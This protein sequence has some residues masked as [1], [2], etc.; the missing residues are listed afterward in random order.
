MRHGYDQGRKNYPFLIT[1]PS[2][3]SYLPRERH[4]Q[5]QSIAQYFLG[6]PIVIFKNVFVT[7]YSSRLNKP[8]A[9]ITQ[10]ENC[11]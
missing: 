1:Y 10:S 3:G 4:Y 5:S 8:R 9:Q 11:Y 6:F 7:L 2:A